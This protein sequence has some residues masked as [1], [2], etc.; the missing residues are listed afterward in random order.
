MKGVTRTAFENTGLA[1]K[2]TELSYYPAPMFQ[3]QLLLILSYETLW[4][5]VEFSYGWCRSFISGFLSGSF[6]FFFLISLI[7]L[8]PLQRERNIGLLVKTF[9]SL[10]TVFHWQII[11]NVKSYEQREVL[12]TKVEAVEDKISQ[13]R[14]FL[15]GLRD[16]ANKN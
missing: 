8:P 16:G 6:L 13:A 2:L 3:I 10:Y 4:E 7:Y 15:R 5:E 11:M 12:W 9:N 14:G 1:W